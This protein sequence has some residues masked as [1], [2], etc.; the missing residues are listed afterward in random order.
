[1][2]FQREK[3]RLPCTES[4]VPPL[5]TSSTP[6][7]LNIPLLST[8]NRIRNHSASA[9][10]GVPIEFR[11]RRRRSPRGGQSVYSA[12][13]CAFTQSNTADTSPNFSSTVRQIQRAPS[14]RTDVRSA[15]VRPPG[16]L[17]EREEPRAFHTQHSARLF[18]LLQV[19]GPSLT[20][21]KNI[22]KKY[23]NFFLCGS[24]LN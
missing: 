22:K 1:M 24:L 8:L 7:I 6:Y 16:G 19:S 15:V 9:W 23:L 12:A 18:L 5:I 21:G 14:I 20:V 2:S 17:W 11:S 13:E 3:K 10:V 4:R